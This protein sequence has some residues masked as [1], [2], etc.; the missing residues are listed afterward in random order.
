MSME[1]RFRE[2]IVD[3]A[4]GTVQWDCPLA[5]YT[6][7]GIGGPAD[8][9]IEVEGEAELSSLLNYFNVN[10]LAWRFIGKGSNL[11][12]S[13]SGFAGAVLL[14]GKG[15]S[16]IS[17]L[18]ESASDAIRVR[19]GAGCSLV[20]ILK[21]CTDRDFS[22]LEFVAGIPGSLGG[23]VIMNAGAFGQE[24]A[25]VIDALDVISLHSGVETLN[26]E[27]LDFIYRLWKN[28]GTGDKKRIVLSV[29]LHLMRGEKAAIKN[30]CRENLKRRKEKQPKV[31]KNAGSFF[32]N[33]QG[34]S[35]GRLIEASGLKGMSCG[36]AMVSP[37]HANFL[38]NT[39]TATAK[40]VC[41]LMVIVT[42]KVKKDSGIQLFPEVHFL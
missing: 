19:A 32:K 10:G 9:L 21:W 5:P 18:E 13:D 24:M 22:G 12:V 33:P 8:A 17:V 27:G 37:V 40:D 39:G 41:Q 1:K 34:D 7:F 20:K 16:E 6:S 35:A 25:D 3:I 15:F 28:Q 38:V 36:G 26:R 4:V 29:D 14:F 42:E 31:E 30:K 2:G 11:L 23:A